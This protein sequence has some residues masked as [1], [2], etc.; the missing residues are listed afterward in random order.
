MMW[1]GRTARMRR[2]MHRSMARN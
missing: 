2:G 1:T